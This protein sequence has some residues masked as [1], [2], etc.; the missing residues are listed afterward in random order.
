MRPDRPPS[1]ACARLPL[2]L[3][4]SLLPLFACPGMVPDC[5]AGRHRTAERDD[6]EEDE[7]E[8][9]EDDDDD[10]DKPANALRRVGGQ[11]CN[12]RDAA[13]AGRVHSVLGRQPPVA[14]VEVAVDGIRVRDEDRILVSV[15]RG[16]TCLPACLF[17]SLSFSL[18]LSL[19]LSLGPPTARMLQ[20]GSSRRASS[21][22][23][24]VSLRNNDPSLGW[25]QVGDILQT[26]LPNVH[27]FY[28]Q[29][30]APFDRPLPI[31]LDPHVLARLN[32]GLNLIQVRAGAWR[33]QPFCES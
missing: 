23:E 4:L 8:E 18:S 7:E 10:A 24:L 15:K 5:P 30:T 21:V 33:C 16:L 14:A 17:F 13:G 2:E 19:S 25:N 9:E 20:L 29:P 12:M 32:G 1:R 28:G 31:T 26:R 11:G 3:T 27:V 6:G 22:Q